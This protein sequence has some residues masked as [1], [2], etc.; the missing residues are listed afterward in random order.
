MK[1]LLFVNVEFSIQY[2]IVQNIK[3]FSIRLEAKEDTLL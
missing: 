3:N 2:T 1:Q